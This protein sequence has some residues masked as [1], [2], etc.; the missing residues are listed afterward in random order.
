MLEIFFVPLLQVLLACLN[1]YNVLIFIYI[2]ISILLSFG[3]LNRNSAFVYATYSS[4]A[5]LIEPV[6]A[7]IRRIVPTVGFLDL[8]PIILCICLRY[9]ISVF[10]L[11]IL[12]YFP[13]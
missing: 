4:L 9:F 13:R 1:L 5:R 7:P 8:S 2:L 11:I 10:G 3:V 6:L 12:K